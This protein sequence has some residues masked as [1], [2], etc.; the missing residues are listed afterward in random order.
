VNTDG[1]FIFLMDDSDD[2]DDYDDEEN[3]RNKLLI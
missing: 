3:R 2:Y 1:T